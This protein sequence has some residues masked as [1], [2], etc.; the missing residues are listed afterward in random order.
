MRVHLQISAAK[1][2]FLGLAT[3]GAIM[4]GGL[5]YFKSAQAEELPPD[6]LE[7]VKYTKTEKIALTE[8]NP[9]DL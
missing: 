6:T 5:F 2:Y 8:F 4:L 9:N 7:N 1:N 3:S